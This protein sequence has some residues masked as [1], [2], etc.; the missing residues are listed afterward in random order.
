MPY[1]FD[2]R[3]NYKLEFHLWLIKKAEVQLILF[4]WDQCNIYFVSKLLALTLAHSCL[5]FQDESLKYVYEQFVLMRWGF[6][7]QLLGFYYCFSL[8]WGGDTLSSDGIWPIKFFP[9]K[10]NWVINNVTGVRMNSLSTFLLVWYLFVF[11]LCK[12]LQREQKQ[13]S[14]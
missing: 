2:V 13:F 10:Q 7:P 1:L 3:S 5:L 12:K 9:L 14:P 11:I 6:S 8:G 4:S